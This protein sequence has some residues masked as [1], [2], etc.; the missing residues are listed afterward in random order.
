MYFFVYVKNIANAGG[1]GCAA[2]FEEER[3]VNFVEKE[4]RQFCAD[5]LKDGQG[6]RGATKEGFAACDC[7][8]R[9]AA[10]GAQTTEIIAQGVIE[11]AFECAAFLL[12]FFDIAVFVGAKDLEREC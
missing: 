6:Q 10:Q 9:I 2:K 12:Y 11:D 4:G 8:I 3:G 1:V 7:E 5:V